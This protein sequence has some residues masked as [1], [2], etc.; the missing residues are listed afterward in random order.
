MKVANR[1]PIRAAIEALEIRP[2]DAILELGF[3]PGDGIKRLA[4]LAPS[5]KIRGID[6]SPLMLALARKRNRRE[7]RSGHVILQQASF[8]NLPLPDACVDKILAVN[9]VYFWDDARP[10]LAEARRV[11]R[12]GGLVS[13]YAT[14]ASAMRSWKFAGPE[15]HRI[16]DRRALAELLQ[17]GGFDT[18]QI[19]VAEVR[20]VLNVHGLIA[21]A[22]KCWQ[23]RHVVPPIS[24]P[25]CRAR[26][27]AEG[28]R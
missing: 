14:D 28:R 26:D 21:T 6:K 20:T 9:V 16:F 5:G 23:A 12:P 15:T 25:C 8:E 22:R 4:A 1:R 27:R 10:V 7:I 3:G 24:P 11:L 2:A 13:I 17:D 19:H 18:D